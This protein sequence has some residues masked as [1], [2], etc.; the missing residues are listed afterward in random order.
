MRMLDNCGFFGSAML[1]AYAECEGPIPSARLQDGYCRFYNQN[2][3][4]R[5]EDGA[6]FA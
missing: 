6:F 5:K 3:L 2:R 1:E 4:E